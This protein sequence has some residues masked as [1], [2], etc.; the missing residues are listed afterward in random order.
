[1]RIGG[2]YR[3]PVKGLSPEALQRV[4]LT[5]GEFFPGD[6]I[7]A[8]ANGP[9]AYDREQPAFLPKTKFLML[10]RQA[11]LACLST[12]FDADSRRLTIRFDGQELA[13][14]NVDL[15]EGRAALQSALADFC[16]QDGLLGPPELLLATQNH[17]FTDSIRSGFVSILN[18]A[19]V[20]ALED[21]I[22]R[23]VDLRRFRAN[24]I[25]DSDAPWSER[26]WLG[27]RL[28]VGDLRLRLTKAIDRCAATEVDPQAGRR[29]LPILDAMK[30][31]WGRIDCGVYASVEASGALS[32]G[33]QANLID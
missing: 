6:R 15:A 22:G 14:A 4:A 9:V 5:K 17:R 33:D 31:A 20:Q 16:A 25:L 18:A 30:R 32:I 23:P 11:R 26:D 10:M 1:M 8:F 28:V 2:L 21:E 7:L 19:S 27:K 13:A 12:V 29:D 3:Y 24:V